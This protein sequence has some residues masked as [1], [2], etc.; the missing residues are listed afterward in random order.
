MRPSPNPLFRLLLW[1][2]LAGAAAAV[3]VIGGLLAT[4]AMRIRHLIFSSDM[5]AVPL[6]MLSIG[7]LIT[8]CSVAMGSAVMALGSDEDGDTHGRR[9]PVPAAEPRPVPVEIVA[10]TRRPRRR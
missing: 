5:P 8:L 3:I 9:P 10:E 1:N 4:D 2:W 7:F 6:A